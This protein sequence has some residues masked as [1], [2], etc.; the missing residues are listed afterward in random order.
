MPDFIPKIDDIR[1]THEFIEALKGAKLDSEIEP[2]DPDFLEC[3]RNPPEYELCLDDPDVILSIEIFLATLNGSKESYEGVCTAILKKHPE[4]EMLSYH[5]VRKEITLLTGVVPI[6]RDMCIKSC[7][8]FTGP[9]RLLNNCPTCDE[10]RYAKHPK[11]GKN[12]VRQH[13]VTI[14]LAPQLQAAWRSKN[15]AQ[16]M[17]YREQ[18]QEQIFSKFTR[19]SNTRPADLPYR[20][21]LD[22][23]E[24]I[25]YVQEGH[26]NSHDSI[27]LVSLDGAQLYANKVSD[28]WVYS[29]VLLGLDPAVHYKCSGLKPGAIIPGK[30]KNYDSF[31]FPGMYHL[32]A[33]QNEGLKIWDAHENKIYIDKPFLAFGTA[34]GPGMAAMSGFVGHH[35]KMHCRVYCPMKGRHKAGAKQYYPARLKP[36]GDYTVSGCDHPDVNLRELLENFDLKESEERY[37]KNLDHLIHST[38]PTDFKAR[39]LE[40]GLCKPCLFSGLSVNRSLGI[41]AM[42][43]LDIMHLPCLNIPDLL[44]PLWRGTLD[45]D[46]A[47]DS[48]E[49]W[50]WVS[51]P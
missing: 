48:R 30:P 5:R 31:M 47:T 38:G 15:G 12:V 33:L 45:Y 44:I 37:N 35:G 32:A 7:V 49:S 11:T 2:L 42:F 39:R 14:P 46:K 26:I 10:P 36:S 41:P 29:W 51:G 28:F 17:H 50:D 43:P 20:D 27:L 22:S 21:F 23:E 1:I 16:Q 8:A 6:Y 19:N 24:Y 18:Y 13:F 34:D 9:F 4:C 25:R 3:I 40:T